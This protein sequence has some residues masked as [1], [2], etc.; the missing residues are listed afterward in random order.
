MP[1]LLLL[2]LALL[3][4]HLLLD[5]QLLHALHQL[6]HVALP[7]LQDLALHVLRCLLQV[8]AKRCQSFLHAIPGV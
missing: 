1:L 3:V 4:L 2:L 7:R 6:A 8:A 5:H